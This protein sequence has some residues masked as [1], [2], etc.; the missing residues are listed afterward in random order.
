MPGVEVFTPRL[1]LAVSPATC[2][3][4]A[5]GSLLARGCGFALGVHLL[6]ATSAQ[7]SLI[8]GLVALNLALC[9]CW[10]TLIIS[11]CCCS[12]VLDGE[13]CCR[14]HV[15]PAV[16]VTALLPLQLA[17]I[18]LAV[19]GAS[20]AVAARGSGDDTTALL[21]LI[22]G[23]CVH[24][25]IAVALLGLASR[26]QLSPGQRGNRGDVFR[27][28]FCCVAPRA[29]GTPA[30]GRLACAACGASRYCCAAPLRDGKYGDLFETLGSTL[31]DYLGDSDLVGSDIILGALLLYGKQRASLAREHRSLQLR[32][33]PAWGGEGLFHQQAT[34]RGAAMFAPPALP[35]TDCDAAMLPDAS[36]AI[37]EA[38]YFCVY[39]TSVYGWK[40][41]SYMHGV[42]GASSTAGSRSSSSAPVVEHEEAP[43][44]DTVA[45]LRVL[46]QPH[47]P[48]PPPFLRTRQSL[49]GEP[50]N[51]VIYVDW[52]C[53]PGERVPI[54]VTLDLR[55]STVVVAC[56]G[57]ITLR[58]TLTDLIVKCDEGHGSAAAAEE[59]NGHRVLG[60][61]KLASLAREY[62]FACVDES[63]DSNGMA[64]SVSHPGFVGVVRATASHLLAT[65]IL[66]ELLL[67]PIG[68]GGEELARTPCRADIL[69]RID[70]VR[71]ERALM[72]RDSDHSEHHSIDSDSADSFRS[73]KSKWS[74]VF[75]GHSLGAATA[76]LLALCLRS[77]YEPH[78][79]RFHCYA[80]SCP[81]AC[82]SHDI[83]AQC[84]A[85][86]TTVVVGDDWVPR[87]SLL[88]MENMRD[89]IVACLVEAALLKE[90]ELQTWWRALF[91]AVR[92]TACWSTT[93][94]AF[95][96]DEEESD[97]IG[98]LE[99]GEHTQLSSRRLTV[100]ALSLPRSGEEG[101]LDRFRAHPLFEKHG[102][103]WSGG[104]PGGIRGNATTTTPMFPLGNILYVWPRARTSV[105]GSSRGCPDYVSPCSDHSIFGYGDCFGVTPFHRQ[106]KAVGCGFSWPSF[107]SR[108]VTREEFCQAAM[109]ISTLA[110][111]DHFPNK[112]QHALYSTS[113]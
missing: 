57:T 63:D 56:R 55:T 112:V 98:G 14:R 87:L 8:C 39:A 1:K 6:L 47:A 50:I 67:P 97:I 102:A 29:H 31:D 4:L 110:L 40:L 93:S 107:T 85:F 38:L 16:M 33:A 88:A 74:L 108:W 92:W 12:G 46:A 111:D 103:A 23:C 37:A 19:A 18:A 22:V 35:R 82:G 34:V 69:A 13:R 51:E 76:G 106:A 15:G 36:S 99:R 64:A 58:D 84:D 2:A 44:R 109:V 71:R 10:F 113:S 53:V 68:R 42:H 41:E 72:S 105:C 91:A 3:L 61:A 95:A 79:S 60:D 27:V 43:Y 90:T 66:D 86:C 49:P 20:S 54:S 48:S 59:E 24:G 80:Y 17:E 96:E 73:L 9:C 75:V 28:L 65:G 100:D 101:E 77:R 94:A 21:I 104:G 78:C 32:T 52:L 30:C 83:A 5:L 81:G 7:R 89:A 11:A 62:G 70:Y 26:H 25:A 45:M